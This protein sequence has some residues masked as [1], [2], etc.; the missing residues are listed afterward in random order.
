[1]DLFWAQASHPGILCIVGLTEALINSLNE[2][3]VS[4]LTDFSSQFFN[5]WTYD[6]GVTSRRV[7]VNAE[8]EKEKVVLPLIN[9]IFVISPN[10][11]ADGWL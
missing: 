6:R 3:I 4:T 1:M 10:N 2:G 5:V 7:T 11:P 9:C 8:S